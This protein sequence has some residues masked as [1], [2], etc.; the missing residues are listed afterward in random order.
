MSA[1]VPPNPAFCGNF[2]TCL[3]PILRSVARAWHKVTASKAPSTRNGHTSVIDAQQ[4]IWVF[5][6]YGGGNFNDLHYFDIQ[7]KVW[8]EVSAQNTPSERYYHTAVMDAKQRMWVFGGES[9]GDA[10]FNDLHYFDM[11]AKTWRGVNASNPPPGRAIHSAVMDAQQRMWIFGGLGSGSGPVL[12]DLQC[13]DIQAEAWQEVKAS[14]APSTAGGHTAVMDGQQRMWI[15]GGRASRSNN[16]LHYFDIQAK[17]WQEVKASNP[18]ERIYHT[19]VMDLKQRMWIFGGWAD[20]YGYRSWNDLRYF[21]TQGYTTSNSTVTTSKTTSSSASATSTTSE[22]ITSTTT[23]STST[24]SKK[25]ALADSM[26]PQG[27]DDILIPTTST[28]KSEHFLVGELPLPT[29]WA[30]ANASVENPLAAEPPFKRANDA[31]L[32]VGIVVSM[33]L[34]CLFVFISFGIYRLYRA[35][36]LRQEGQAA[37]PTTSAREVEPHSSPPWPVL[38]AITSTAKPLLFGWDSRMTAEWPRGKVL[39]L[40]VGETGFEG[41][42]QRFPFR[43]A[44]GREF[45]WEDGT[46]QRVAKIQ[47]NV[48]WWR[49]QHERS[50]WQHFRWICT[51][52]CSV[53]GHHDM[54]LTDVDLYRCSSCSSS[55]VAEKHWHC[56]AH[57][58][59][60]CPTCA[61]LPP[62]TPTLGV[63]ANYVVNVF[64]TL[65]SCATGQE[66]PDF[67]A[68]CPHFAHG[69]NGLGVN[70]ICPRD[71]RPQCSVVD[72]VDDTYSGKVTHFV[73]WCWAYYLKSV[74][75]AVE[76]WLHKSGEDPQDVFLWMCFFC[77]NQYRIKEEATQTGNHRATGLY[78]PSL[79]HFRKLRL[80]CTGHTDVHH[81][82]RN[83]GKFLPGDSAN[84]RDQHADQSCGCLKRAACKSFIRSR[85]GSDQEIDPQRH[86]F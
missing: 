49:T 85:R 69:S 8:Q 39:K 34:T 75:S 70:K 76:G 28:S 42:G 22:E 86:W 14:N 84:R 32:I 25:A 23:S 21:D 5:G 51:P 72:A 47:Q 66:N 45:C 71:G 16:A 38:P 58:V 78:H 43:Q 1:L 33:L 73:S 31:W 29:S 12:H 59:H 55:R 40:T 77:N 48:V 20:D 82:P 19:A 10:Y 17:T 3:A 35:R 7:A 6:G 44:D 53:G 61:E 60:L 15:F 79:V 54:H 36:K 13:F 80:H 62:E 52:K 74:V 18:F 41:K 2:Y 64:P 11:K 81:S 30:L 67:Y 65:A 46:V 63:A 26:Q 56:P 50:E 57:K 83:S 27:E 9:Y 4:R 24:S 68:I 37:S